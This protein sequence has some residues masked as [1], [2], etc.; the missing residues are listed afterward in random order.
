MLV[1]RREEGEQTGASTRDCCCCGE[2]K[3]SFALLKG[4]ESVG[5]NVEFKV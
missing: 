1:G 4:S 5:F 3:S 2:A